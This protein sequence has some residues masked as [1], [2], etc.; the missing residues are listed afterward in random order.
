MVIQMADGKIEILSNLQ[1]NCNDDQGV[2]YGR[3]T[4]NYSDG[5]RPTSWLGSLRIL[6]KWYKTN[7]RPVK[8]GQCWVF[9]GVMC[10]GTVHAVLL[11][12]IT[13]LSSNIRR[14]EILFDFIINFQTLYLFL[15]TYVFMIPVMRFFGIPCRVVTN[16]ESA[17]DT[18]NNLTVDTFY[19]E[20]GAQPKQSPE[21][22]W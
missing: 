20:K 7:C 22:I 17:H 10:T 14:T 3:W 18:N 13:V 21:R 16:F 9:A 2:L 15:C 1:I 12:C 5:E 6:R 11:M 4:D 19:G 8:Y